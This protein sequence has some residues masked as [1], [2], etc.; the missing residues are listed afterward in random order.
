M[1]EDEI[2]EAIN[3]VKQIQDVI[4]KQHEEIEKFTNSESD[5][6]LEWYK[7]DKVILILKKK[8]EEE[9]NVA[10]NLKKLINAFDE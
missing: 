10:K 8:E 7:C 3:S 6:P 4:K 9:K 5:Y 2:Q 1:K